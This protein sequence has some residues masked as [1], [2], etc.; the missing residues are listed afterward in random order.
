MFKPGF[1][2]MIGTFSIVVGVMTPFSV[3]CVASGLACV[4]FGIK[5]LYEESDGP[6]NRD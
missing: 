5:G 2:I 1:L 3:L 6:E 4:G